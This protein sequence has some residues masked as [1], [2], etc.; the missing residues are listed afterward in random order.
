MYDEERNE[1]T[2]IEETGNEKGTGRGKHRS[3]WAKKAAGIT[4]AAVLFG[5]V[6]GGVM[7]TVGRLLPR[8]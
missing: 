7:R 1:R 5:T 6:S 2:I 3:S 4:A 8:P